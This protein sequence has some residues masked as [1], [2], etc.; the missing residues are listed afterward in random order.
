VEARGTGGL[1]VWVPVPDETRAVVSL[2][3]AGWGA[4]PGAR[5]RLGAPPGVRITVSPLSPDDLGPLADAVAEAVRPPRGVR[6]G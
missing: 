1:N 4:A 6:Y 3:H 2:L 5:F